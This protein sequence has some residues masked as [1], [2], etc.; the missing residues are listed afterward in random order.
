MVLERL[1]EELILLMILVTIEDYLRNRK[2]DIVVLSHLLFVMEIIYEGREVENAKL[3]EC[4]GKKVEVL[5]LLPVVDYPELEKEVISLQESKND[6][7]R[8]FQVQTDI[9]NV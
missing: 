2:G 6:E 8:S 1:V 5:M 4:R 9:S 7:L 3:L